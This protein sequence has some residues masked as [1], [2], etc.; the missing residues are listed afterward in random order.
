MATAAY[1]KTENEVW[2]TVRSCQ[3]PIV[4]LLSEWGVKME[5]EEEEKKTCRLFQP[6]VMPLRIC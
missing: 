4:A 6:T 2:R 3:P 1:V 5:M